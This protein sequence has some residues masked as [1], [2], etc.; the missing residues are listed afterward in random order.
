MNITEKAQHDLILVSLNRLLLNVEELDCLIH[1]YDSTIITTRIDEIWGE[2][3]P[4][5]VARA[6][7]FMKRLVE[8]MVI[9]VTEYIR[10]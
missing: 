4:R 1:L 3:I 10:D 8:A 6:I 2:P 7:P 9:K 5:D